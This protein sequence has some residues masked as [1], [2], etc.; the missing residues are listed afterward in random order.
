M[1]CIGIINGEYLANME[2][3]LDVYEAES[4]EKVVRLCFD[5]RPTQLLG[6]VLSP[7]RAKPNR[8]RKEH[9]EYLRNGV[10][11]VLLAYNI[12]TGQRHLR[13]TDTKKKSDYA[14][15]M[16]WLSEEVYPEATKIILVQDNYG[17]HSYGA[18]YE[19]LPPE[20]AR[21][22]KNK[23]EFHF[24]PK[25]ASWLNMAEMEF[26]SLARQCLDRRIPDKETLLKEAIIWE[27]KRNQ[28][29]VK[30]NWSF[31]TEKARIKLKSRYE[32]ISI[33]TLN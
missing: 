10:C 27:Q 29:S 12:E 22:L 8:T 2:D 9:Q 11:N 26:S 15:F 13:V 21:I 4:V 32:E 24:T 5:E 17:S 30:V 18:F 14:S 19:N 23:F 28:L 31:T 20:E 25:H 16:K 6:E 7:I 33:N 3:V 1:W